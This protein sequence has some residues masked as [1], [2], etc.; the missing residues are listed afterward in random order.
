MNFNANFLKDSFL[1]ISFLFSS[2][3]D[4]IKWKAGHLRA[5]GQRQV[6]LRGQ[7][8]HQS[9]PGL[10][11]NGHL[12]QSRRPVSGEM[13]PPGS[14]SRRIV[15]I[16]RNFGL[17]LPHR[18]R[19]C[20][21]S[22][23]KASR[24]ASGRWNHRSA[25]SKS[26][27]DRP[28]RRRCW[29]DSRTAKFPKSSSTIRSLSTCSRSIWPSAVWIWAIPDA[30]WPS[31]T[32]TGGYNI[33]V[34]SFHNL[35]HLICSTCSVYNLHNGE[36]LYQVKLTKSW[37]NFIKLR[38][39]FFHQE[40]N[41]NSVSWN[42]HCEDMICFSG[43][44]WLNIKASNFPCHQQK[45]MGYVVGFYGSKIFCL[46]GYNMTTIEVPLSAPMYQYLDRKFFRYS[47]SQ[48]FYLHR[49]NC[50]TLFQFHLNGKL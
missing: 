14:R 3:K 39:L 42:I 7:G 10:Q 34:K 35:I 50:S 6:A 28:T 32:T 24:N 17:R 4:S 1:I 43:Q 47:F 16:R 2:V 44:N 25:T 49:N 20:N 22:I 5:A 11:P 41:A 8:A 48:S 19:N 18:R 45:F 21:R 26:S 36:L 40:P 9:E 12:Y 27:A 30:K 31:S 23:S 29:S 37:N 33:S 38:K 13:R 46:Q 15:V